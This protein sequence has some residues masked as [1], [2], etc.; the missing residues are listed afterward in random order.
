MGSRSG[1]RRERPTGAAGPPLSPA[2]LETRVEGLGEGE[3]PPPVQKSLLAASASSGPRRARSGPSAP[4]YRARRRPRRRPRLLVPAVPRPSGRGAG[5][6]TV[7]PARPDAADEGRGA[8]GRGPPRARSRGG[9][10]DDVVVDE[11]SHHRPRS[12][13]HGRE[14]GRGRYSVPSGPLTR[15]DLGWGPGGRRGLGK[16]VLNVERAEVSQFHY[17]P[18][19]RS[20]PGHSYPFTPVNSGPF[21]PEPLGALPLPTLRTPRPQAPTRAP[22]PAPTRSS[23]PLL[24]RPNP[25]SVRAS[26]PF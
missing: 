11:T 21:P 8:G 22:P 17:T 12:R 9:G 23:G 14:G 4:C 26:T 7:A 6:G 16:H 24:R 10:G 3:A 25:L 19:A 18:L 13:P 20:L 2:R 5:R 1:A 15:G